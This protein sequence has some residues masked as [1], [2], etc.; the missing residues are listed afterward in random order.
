MAQEAT[1]AGGVL[2]Y[3]VVEWRSLAGGVGKLC[4]KESCRR[5]GLGER[6]LRTALRVLLRRRV[7]VCT[8]H[9][10]PQRAAAVALYRK[11]GFVQDGEAV[12][13]YY[14]PGRDAWRMALEADIYKARHP[15]WDADDG[16]EVLRAIV[17]G[18]K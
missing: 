13:D 16:I 15:H 3:A 7:S 11:L 18:R 4:V 9:V 10:D 14:A 12:K 8:L 2:A 5:R 17:T 6:T 1:G